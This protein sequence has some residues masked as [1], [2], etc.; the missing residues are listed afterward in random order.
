MREIL[1]PVAGDNAPDVV[2]LAAVV[3]QQLNGRLVAGCLADDPFDPF[4]CVFVDALVRLP[5]FDQG[6]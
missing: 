4:G 2:P 5:L 1:L 3:A 6:S